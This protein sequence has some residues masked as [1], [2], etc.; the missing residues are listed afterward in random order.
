MNNLR[1][2]YLLPCEQL[3]CIWANSHLF[4]S[5]RGKPVLPDKGF[6]EVWEVAQLWNRTFRRRGKIPKTWS[7][8][9]CS[10]S[11][12]SNCPRNSKKGSSWAEEGKQG[13]LE[14]LIFQKK[15]HFHQFLGQPFFTQLIRVIFC[16]LSDIS[17]SLLE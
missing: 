9:F 3:C 6:S 4:W 12:R 15:C 7:T 10:T 8:V 17:W 5:R 1:Y 14:G 2:M 16:K 11:S 13:L